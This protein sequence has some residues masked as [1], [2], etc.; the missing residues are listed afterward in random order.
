M[1]RSWHL[2]SLSSYVLLNM[3]RFPGPPLPPPRSLIRYY[4]V[5][6][7]KHSNHVISTILSSTLEVSF[8]HRVDSCGQAITHA[9]HIYLKARLFKTGLTKPR[10][11]AKLEF[12]YDTLESS[13][14]F[15]NSWWLDYACKW[16]QHVTS[17]NVPSVCAG[18]QTASLLPTFLFF[19]RTCHKP[20]S[21]E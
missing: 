14:P 21:N 3:S 5:H 13:I 11:I 7:W 6:R 18:F 2:F 17:N 20:A 8:S 1:G 12:R 16:T 19:F 15:V 4:L 9:I 10:V